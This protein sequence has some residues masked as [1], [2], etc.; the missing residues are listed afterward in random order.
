MLSRPKG[1]VNGLLADAAALEMAWVVV[2][3][4]NA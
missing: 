2:S 4:L 1:N 3:E